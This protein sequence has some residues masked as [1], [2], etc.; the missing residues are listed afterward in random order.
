MNTLRIACCLL[1]AGLAAFGLVVA[2]SE[3]P[4]ETRLLVLDGIEIKLADAM[5]F[6]EYMDTY[7]PDIGRKTKL[8]NVLERYLI[9]VALARR[10]FGAQRAE[11][12]QQAE[13]M[14]AVATN[15]VEL[16]TKSEL[17]AEKVKRDE[18][19]ATMSPPE[20]IF[21]FDP[22]RTG[23]VSRPIEVPQG[24][25]VAGAF[26]LKP[27]SLAM[28]DIVSSLRVGFVTHTAKQWYDYYEEQK[29]LLAT[30]A[31]FVH[32]DWVTAMPEWIQPPRQP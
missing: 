1:P 13:A 24:W 21:L 30:K 11:K 2:C 19:R 6:V 18:S 22:L 15:V 26:D 32:P 20:A 27:R 12:L 31:T 3:P 7:A 28:D 10:Q 14:C 23:E 25:Y 4:P 29:R 9:P 16:E 17:I 8:M 5:P